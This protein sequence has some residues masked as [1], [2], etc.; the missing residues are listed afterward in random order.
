VIS[1]LSG[2]RI[3]DLTTIVLGPYATAILGDLG[4]DVIKVEPPG[5]DL[6]GATAPSRNPG[7]GAPF[8]T[9]NRNKRSISLDL[10]KPDGA[11]ALNALVDTADV[12]IH[13]LL[14]RVA[15]KLGV[16]AATLTKRRPRLIHCTT[17][18]FGSEGPDA[19]APAYDDVIQGRMGLASLLADE[20]GVAPLAPTTLAD[21]VTGLHAAIA[22]LGALHHRERTGEGTV[23]EVPM[24]ETMASFLLA[25]H[26]GGRAFDPP[27]GPPG[28]NRLLNPHRRP[29]PTADGYIVMLP[30]SAKHWR[31]VLDLIGDR[32]W[33]GAGWVFDSELRARR[34]DELYA[35]LEAHTPAR[36]T[37]EWLA[38][39]AERGIPAGGVSTL[40]DLF[41]DPQLAAVAFFEPSDHP[42]E[43]PVV[44]PAS[45]IRVAGHEPH[46]NLHTPRAGEHGREVFA[47]LGY[48]DD[49]INRM[50]AIGALIVPAD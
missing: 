10:T 25:E 48:D 27:L 29:Y 47:G 46:R 37:G 40:D 17:P 45:P 22:V 12:V 14:P 23:L 21:K 44:D 38:A 15:M 4:A 33:I 30:Y 16:D 2:V 32:A 41:S 13:N 39:L 31:D 43:G 8:L 24:L 9:I 6:Y 35:L 20:T 1:L 50:I 5:G 42:S 34:I 26:M 18:G 7:M 11:E 19:D 28:Y 49:K 36:T 3:V